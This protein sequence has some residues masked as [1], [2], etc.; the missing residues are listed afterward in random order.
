M[1]YDILYQEALTNWT[2]VAFHWWGNTTC[3][4]NLTWSHYPWK[5]TRPLDMQKRP[6]QLRHTDST[7]CGA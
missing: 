3:T 6:V 5:T 1:G 2:I 7:K 4:K